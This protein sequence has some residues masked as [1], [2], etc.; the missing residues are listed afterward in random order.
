MKKIK[1]YILILLVSSAMLGCIGTDIVEDI[2]V[3]QSVSISNRLE[4]LAVGDS[5]QFEANFFDE[6]GEQATADITWSSNNEA[7]MSITASGLATGVSQGD[8]WISA[9]SGVARDSVMVS[10]GPSTTFAA[11]ERTGSFVG[12]RDYNVSGNFT[13]TEDGDNLVLTFASNFMASRGPG[14]FV[15]LSNNSTRVNGGVEMG[16]LMQ[17][18]GAQ[19]YTIALTEAQLDTYNHVLIYCKPFGVAFG[20]GQFDN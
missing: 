7:V 1:F 8:V 12:L 9:M 5:Y 3:N 19:T 10:V 6:M 20:T 15:Y 2:I 18:S 14:L 16:Q 4:T 11:A 17:N 13:L